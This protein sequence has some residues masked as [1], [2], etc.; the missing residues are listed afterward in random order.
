[1]WMIN[2]YSAIQ[3]DWHAQ[4]PCN[5]SSVWQQH[6][7]WSFEHTL[8]PHSTFQMVVFDKKTHPFISRSVLSE[9][10]EDVLVC[11]ASPTSTPNGEAAR[12]ICL[13]VCITLPS[14]WYSREKRACR[15]PPYVT[16][17]QYVKPDVVMRCTDVT[18]E[19]HLIFLSVYMW[20]NFA[21][22]NQDLLEEEEFLMCLCNILQ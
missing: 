21:N 14:L 9:S 3:N 20:P 2:L 16:Y 15:C 5:R 12:R 19:W 18:P 6:P 22:L 1:M 8:N 4:W 7:L 13:S 11:C 10:G 17:V